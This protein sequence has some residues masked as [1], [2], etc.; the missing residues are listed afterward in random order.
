MAEHKPWHITNM[1]KE[2]RRKIKLYAIQN[3]MEIAEVIT[4]M[5]NKLVIKNK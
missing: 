4:E 1:P 5:A 3:D 2:P